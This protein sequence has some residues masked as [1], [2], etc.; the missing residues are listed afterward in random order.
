MG[1]QQGRNDMQKRTISQAVFE[2]N[3]AKRAIKAGHK[4]AC[5]ILDRRAV[6]DIPES[7]PNH[8]MYS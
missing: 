3:E 8:P 5:D 4:M 2:S 7:D 1:H 6:R